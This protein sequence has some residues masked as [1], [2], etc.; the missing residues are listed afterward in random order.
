M[1][2][3]KRVREMAR[4]A[5]RLRR[6]RETIG[7]VPTMGALHEGHLSLIR[8]ARRENE[9]VVV[10]V[11]VNPLQFGPHEDFAQYPR[12]LRRD[13]RLAASEGTDV[14]FAPE[15]SEMY[16]E[17]FCT[18]V[19]VEGISR[20]LEGVMRPGHFRGVTTVVA[21]LFHVVQPTRAYLGQKDYQQAVIV[22]RMVEDLHLPVRIRVLPTIREPDG[23]AMSSRNA[24]LPRVERQQAAVLFRAL[25]WAKDAIH[26]GE[27]DP[28]R[29]RRRLSELMHQQ[30][31]L[32]VQEIALVDAKTLA[33]LKILRGRVAILV[34]A[35]LGRTRLIDNLLVDVT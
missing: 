31:R 8:A 13:V 15:A 23:L 35:R 16:P 9:T 10:S 2:V 14:V 32:R 22:T 24:Y 21:T 7:F 11:F 28:K 4:L 30:P 26:H 12:D 19:E 20:R 34:A 17:G 33:P 29:L 18:H 25:T 27:R 3:V 1:Q 6:R 5:E